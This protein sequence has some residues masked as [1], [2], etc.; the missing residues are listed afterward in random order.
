MAG[1]NIF[2]Q[3]YLSTWQQRELK[4]L[5]WLDVMTIDLSTQPLEWQKL[6]EASVRSINEQPLAPYYL[7]FSGDNICLILNKHQYFKTLA[8]YL[9]N[10]LY[11]K[12]VD[13]YVNMLNLEIIPPGIIED[14]ED[15]MFHLVFPQ[16]FI[17]FYL[18]KW[19]LVNDFEPDLSW[20]IRRVYVSK[21]WVKYYDY[22][23]T[24]TTFFQDFSA[25]KNLACTES[26]ML[27]YLNTLT[28]EN[29]LWQFLMK[30][31]VYLEPFLKSYD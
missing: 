10:Y 2:T 29:F 5:S 4:L 26:A 28:D 1:F 23:K 3:E 22:L 20:D 25:I 15:E 16:V 7:V 31:L 14:T 21:L 30:F 24:Q 8:I 13:F 9:S 18:A 12:K 17:P 27:T 19:D 11:S 6:Y